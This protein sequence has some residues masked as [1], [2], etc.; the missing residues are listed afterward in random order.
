MP[1]IPVP[2]SDT[3]PDTVYTPTDIIDLASVASL[4]LG[5]Q[6]L[7]C[8]TKSLRGRLDRGIY[9][10]RNVA[11]VAALKALS[12]A[13]DGDMAFLPGYGLY[14]YVSGPGHEDT[15]TDRGT[16]WYRTNSNAGRWENV[17]AALMAPLGNGPDNIAT[18][19]DDGRI[20]AMPPNAIVRMAKVAAQAE[21]Q[22]MTLTGGDVAGVLDCGY[23]DV[24]D[25]VL[26]FGR[27][28]L[29]PNT[30]YQSFGLSIIANE[31]TGYSGSVAYGTYTSHY[32][33]GQPSVYNSVQLVGIYTVQSACSLTAKLNVT[34][35]PAT[36]GFVQNWGMQAQVVRP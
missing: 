16:L 2:E 34:A 25:Q 11:D 6:P 9:R 28:K 12:A 27:A 32:E 17:V 19:N 8:R 22:I 30:N 13:T 26:M 10:L 35:S 36:S 31:S 24:G 15:T 7:A 18:I 1:S 21:Q 3:Y 33:D 14:Y 29:R 4:R 20:D 23:C 5:L